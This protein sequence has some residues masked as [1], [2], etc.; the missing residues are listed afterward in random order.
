[1]LCPL[2]P[3]TN[4]RSLNLE[5]VSRIDVWVFDPPPSDSSR[6]LPLPRAIRKDYEERGRNGT[7]VLDAMPK[8]ALDLLLDHYGANSGQMIV[9]KCSDDKAYWRRRFAE[10]LMTALNHPGLMEV[11]AA[12]PC[13]W[14]RTPPGTG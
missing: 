12:G 6:N 11:L 10:G 8:E 14:L 9:V 7:F 5:L 3:A 4:R 13:P 1:V 2:D